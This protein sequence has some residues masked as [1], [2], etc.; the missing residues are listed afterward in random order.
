MSEPSII[1]NE[2]NER[3]AVFSRR[4]FLL[5]SAAGAGLG[6]LTGR[7]AQ[8]QIIENASY[9]AAAEEN[10]F[11][12]NLV[13]PPRGLII[14]RNDVT[15]ASSR[16][17]F[18]VFVTP[19]QVDDMETTLA[20]IGEILE[21]DEAGLE[22]LKT[23]ISRS[24]SYR[25][26]SL[27]DDLTWEQFSAINVRAPELPGVTA[28]MGEA[29]IYPFGGT[30]AHIL[31][32]VQR[33]GPEDFE[34]TNS[35]RNEFTL[36]PG[37][38]IGQRGIE[39]AF[40]HEL[41]GKPGFEMVEVDARGRIV[42][43]NPAGDLPPTQGDTIRL[44]LDADVQ[45]RALEVFGEESGAA[46]LM[47][48][49]SG[50][51]LCLASAPSFDPN[52]FITGLSNAEFQALQNYERRPL[53]DKAMS[54]VYP[55]GSTFKTMT[56]MAA[57][58][59]G[60]DPEVRV[61]CGG[62][63]RVG[64]A[65]FRCHSVHGSQNMHDALR[66]SC[67]VYFY[68]TAMNMGPRGTGVDKIA[69]I[70]HGFGLGETFDI[71]LPGQSRGIVPSTTWK[72]EYYAERDPTRV[73]WQPGETPSVA[74]GQGALEVNALQ[75]CVMTARLANPEYK[76]LNPRLINSVGAT[77]WP[78]GSDVPDLPFA[79][80]HVDYVRDGMAAVTAAGGTGFRNSQLDL[81]DILMAGKTGTAQSRSYRGGERNNNAVEW[82]RRD[83]GLFVAF[84][85]I[86]NPK[87]AISV[88]VQHGAGGST[89]AAPRARDIMRVALLKDPEI[90]ARLLNPPG[91][92][93]NE[94]ASTGGPA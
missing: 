31:G 81:G 36:H 86:D 58:E 13:V 32:Y 61:T 16:P 11:D 45:N 1:F 7:L 79:R 67:D 73:A 60:I 37:F 74:I 92:E 44:T 87:Y 51:L 65:V 54:G 38:R 77:E 47:D 59:Y 30:F 75:L 57:L 35:E 6:V 15:L 12:K 63:Y 84:A 89:A 14:D 22:Q 66:N 46:V 90:Q 68:A 91:A 25:P 5:G 10:Q 85:P 72:R 29:R 28:R 93:T 24:A 40:E 70:S 53:N 71:G 62:A 17:N 33:P 78:R 8:L 34:Q 80:E 49:R 48:C 23:N 56:A 43:R 42:G 52:K 20:I 26:V 64:N 69:E 27:A 83:H 18:Q 21:L 39:R 76:A 50:D 94:L 82:L 9:L 88:I 55:P 19:D 41:R 4:V 3:Q 2:V